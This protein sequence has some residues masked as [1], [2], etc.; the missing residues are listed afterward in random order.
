LLRLE[1]DLKK[2]DPWSLGYG[3]KMVLREG[4]KGVGVFTD[5]FGNREERMKLVSSFIAFL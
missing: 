1:S 2:K 4:G 5:S 3:G